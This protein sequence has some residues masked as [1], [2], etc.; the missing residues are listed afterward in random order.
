MVLAAAGNDPQSPPS[1]PVSHELRFLTASQVNH[2]AG[3][4][5]WFPRPQPDIARAQPH[6]GTKI[7]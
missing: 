2:H 3:S 6:V 7:Y 1:A 4:S 5:T